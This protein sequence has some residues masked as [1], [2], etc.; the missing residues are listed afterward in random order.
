M[1]PPTA[2]MKEVGREEDEE[3]KTIRLFLTILS[4]VIMYFLVYLMQM[5]LTLDSH[6]MSLE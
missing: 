1:H 2:I 3:R 4:S 6:E 5:Q